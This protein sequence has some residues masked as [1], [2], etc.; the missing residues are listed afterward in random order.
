MNNKPPFEL[1]AFCFTTAF[2]TNDKHSIDRSDAT[3]NL[4]A[5]L[6]P[7]APKIGHVDK[8]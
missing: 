5:P 7:G 3:I 6:E 4:R 2:Q 1:L 8:H